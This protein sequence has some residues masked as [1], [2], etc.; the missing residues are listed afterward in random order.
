MGLQVCDKINGM[1]MRNDNKKNACLCEAPCARL[2]LGED[3][4]VVRQ[5]LVPLRSGSLRSKVTRR[6]EVAGSTINH[7]TQSL[8]R[9]SVHHLY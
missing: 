2:M 7:L 5:P 9:R 6:L 1:K 4:S 8:T 3:G